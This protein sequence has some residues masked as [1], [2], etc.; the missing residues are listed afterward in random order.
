M[1]RQVEP[2]HVALSDPDEARYDEECKAKAT[3]QQDKNRLSRLR[4]GRRIPRPPDP[5]DVAAAR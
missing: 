2:V 5:I 3:P 4:F 1:L